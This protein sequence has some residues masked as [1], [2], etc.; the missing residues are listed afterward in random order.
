MLEQ[1]VD[2][3]K[4]GSDGVVSLKANNWTKCWLQR[5]FKQ[6]TEAMQCN[7]VNMHSFWTE[8][9]LRHL[10]G[11]DVFRAV[12]YIQAFFKVGKIITVISH[13]L[14]QSSSSIVDIETPFVNTLRTLWR[15]TFLLDFEDSSWGHNLAKRPIQQLLLGF[16]SYYMI[17]ISRNILKLNLHQ[18]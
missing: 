8:I 4:S 2:A 17:L 13:D 9:K 1:F 12:K 15:S 14:H 6:T 5:C 3:L 11:N 16:Q 7:I 10:H 18:A